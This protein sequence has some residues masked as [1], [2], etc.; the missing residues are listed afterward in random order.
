MERS[1]NSADTSDAGSGAVAAAVGADTV[2]FD[3]F[4]LLDGSESVDFKPFVAGVTTEFGNVVVV[5]VEP[6]FVAEEDVVAVV[7]VVEPSAVL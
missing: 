3:G 7:V 6:G 2:P 5:V 4:V 1:L